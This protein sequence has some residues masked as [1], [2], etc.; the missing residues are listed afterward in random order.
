MPR[1]IAGKSTA[2]KVVVK[3]S[4]AASR[5]FRASARKAISRHAK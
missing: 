2:K 5:E 4:G 1:P 3:A